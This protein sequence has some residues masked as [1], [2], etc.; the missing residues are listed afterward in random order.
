MQITV[1]YSYYIFYMNYRVQVYR[2]NNG[3]GKNGAGKN[4]LGK[5][6][7]RENGPS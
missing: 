5:N 7:P 4:G 3:P 1:Q 6:G 2:P